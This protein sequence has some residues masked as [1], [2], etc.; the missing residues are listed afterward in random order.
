M[1]APSPT[2]FPYEALS[3]QQF[4][5]QPVNGK[6]I[7]TF[8]GA[9]TILSRILTCEEIHLYIA[10]P[11]ETGEV[12]KLR[13][14]ADILACYHI[15]PVSG[16]SISMSIDSES[17]EYDDMLSMLARIMTD[18][19]LSRLRFSRDE[20]ARSSALK[21]LAKRM[22]LVAD[23]A[24]ESY[25]E[26]LQRFHVGEP[27]PQQAPLNDR[28]LQS[29]KEADAKG[30]WSFEP[31]IINLPKMESCSADISLDNQLVSVIVEGLLEHS[32]PYVSAVP[33][34]VVVAAYNITFKR[35]SLLCSL[36]AEKN[37]YR[38]KE[39]S[40]SYAIPHSEKCFIIN[41]IREATL[42]AFELTVQSPPK[43][44]TLLGEITR[45]YYKILSS[46]ISKSDLFEFMSTAG[47]RQTTEAEGLPFNYCE[48]INLPAPTEDNGDDSQG[49]PKEICNEYE[50]AAE[51]EKLKG[52]SQDLLAAL[53]YAQG[54]SIIDVA[55]LR[56][57][58]PIRANVQRSIRNGLALAEARHLT[59]LTPYL[60]SIGRQGSS[61]NKG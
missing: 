14:R 29:R 24:P 61:K 22:G 50:Q 7:E 8:S 60:E 26:L 15:E 49:I 4:C 11:Y 31:G 17:G 9:L 23:C 5:I 33:L 19:L 16:C 25:G 2:L 59:D 48:G 42:D 46:F 13:E 58:E 10:T 39:L 20:I 30:Q 52:K 40:E 1:T 34:F 44:E 35:V 28:L 54:L 3:L 18:E 36:Y 45:G 21:D 47:E 27:K 56:G 6:T 38:A 37:M 55:T 41:K 53:H 57:I 51:S 43:E 12:L 32:A